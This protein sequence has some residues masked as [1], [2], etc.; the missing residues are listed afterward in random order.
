MKQDASSYCLVGPE[1]LAKLKTYENLAWQEFI[2]RFTPFVV[3]RAKRLVRAQYVDECV[4]DLF[5]YLLVKVQKMHAVTWVYL[6]KAVLIVSTPY[7]RRKTHGG[8][9]DLL[10]VLVD[11]KEGHFEKEAA[12]REAL[13]G[14][15]ELCQAIITCRFFE[16]MTYEE[17]A[18]VLSMTVHQVRYRLQKCLAGLRVILSAD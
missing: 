17:I 6:S 1:F 8:L 13:E 5:G 15:D 18:R 3:G 2:D 14:L 7:R 16:D 4:A 10:N 11:E 12:L 9:K